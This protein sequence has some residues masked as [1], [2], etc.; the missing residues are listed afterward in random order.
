MAGAASFPPLLDLLPVFHLQLPV[1]LVA[2]QVRVDIGGGMVHQHPAQ[3]AH[4]LGG[5]QIP[6]QRFQRAHME[7]R[8]PGF[9]ELPFQ[10]AVDVDA[11]AAVVWNRH[12][13]KL[14]GRE[15]NLIVSAGFVLTGQMVVRD[16]PGPVETT[17]CLC[18]P[19]HTAEQAAAGVPKDLGVLLRREIL[20]Q[21][22]PDLLPVPIMEQVQELFAALELAALVPVPIEPVALLTAA[23]VARLLGKLIVGGAV[24]MVS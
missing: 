20:F 13:I 21:P 11:L 16:G 3:L 17:V 14:I 1:G 19:D 4:D 22:E 24:C 9:V 23:V 12:K 10:I 8:A 2:V 5:I 15:R 18:P 6:L 7:R